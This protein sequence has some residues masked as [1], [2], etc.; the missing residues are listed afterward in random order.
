MNKLTEPDIENLIYNIPDV[1]D[2]EFSDVM[3]DD[4]LFTSL[5]D[6]VRTFFFLYI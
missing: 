5:I 1:S 6:H 4:D 2:D 3:S